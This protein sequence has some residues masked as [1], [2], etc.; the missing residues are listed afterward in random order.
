M[1]RDRL[2]GG[3]QPPSQELRAD[4]R[5]FVYGSRLHGNMT[6]GAMSL[7]HR[8]GNP[9]LAAWVSL[10]LNRQVSDV[11]CGLKALPKDVLSNMPSSACPWGDFDPFF[12]AAD[13]GLRFVEIPVAF[14]PRRTGHSKMRAFSAGLY[15]FYLCAGRALRGLLHTIRRKAL[16]TT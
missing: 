1:E 15:F 10:L 13:A 8:L 16:A 14:A 7:A 5:V 9:F 3:A 6:R 12:A 2:A 4:S 11:L